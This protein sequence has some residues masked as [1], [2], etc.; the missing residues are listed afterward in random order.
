MS[1]WYLK[2]EQRTT[3]VQNVKLYHFVRN[4]RNGCHC[5]ID[6]PL[7]VVNLRQMMFTDS[8]DLNFGLNP[9]RLSFIRDRKSSGDNVCLRSLVCAFTVM[10]IPLINFG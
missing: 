1:C 9:P 5:A 3:E 6:A 2:G 4:A 7:G 8:R 10:G